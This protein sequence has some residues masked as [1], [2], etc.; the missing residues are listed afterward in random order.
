MWKT[1]KHGRPHW[2]DL[3]EPLLGIAIGASL[4]LGVQA[5]SPHPGQ[6]CGR[7]GQIAEEWQLG[8]SSRPLICGATLEGE[9]RY[10]RAITAE[11]KQASLR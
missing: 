7:L 2:P 6:G 1:Q 11:K 9:L 8:S 4:F 5:V 10:E 3:Q